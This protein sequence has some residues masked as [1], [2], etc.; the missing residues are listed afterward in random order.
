MIRVS[1]LIFGAVVAMT[2]AGCLELPPLPEFGPCHPLYEGPEEC[3]DAG[4]D[5]QVMDA[6]EV[7]DS[8][9]PQS[10]AAPDDAASSDACEATEEVCNGL[11]DDCDGETD[12]GDPGGGGRCGT[13]VGAVSSAHLTLPAKRIV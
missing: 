4:Q 9:R 6:G 11:D 8:G 3:P 2:A 13:G 10:D 7:G 12:E 1:L 5:A